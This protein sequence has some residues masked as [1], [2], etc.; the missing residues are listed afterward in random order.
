M[1]RKFLQLGLFVFV[2]IVLPVLAF[3]IGMTIYNTSSVEIRN[4]SDFAIEQ[5]T[6]APSAE[7]TI[8]VLQTIPPRSRRKSHHHFHC[9]TDCHVDYSFRING[10]E[11]KGQLIGYISGPGGFLIEMTVDP[12]T[13][14]A[15]TEKLK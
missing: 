1:N 8:F 12:Q 13:Q 7:G 11:K 9:E 14:V 3:I 4:D 10:I 15:V 2:L 6:F 5:M